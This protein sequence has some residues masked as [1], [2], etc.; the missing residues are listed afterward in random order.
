MEEEGGKG[1][2]VGGQCVVQGETSWQSGVGLG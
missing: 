1:E 2:Q